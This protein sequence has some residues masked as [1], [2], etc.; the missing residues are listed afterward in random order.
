MRVLRLPVPDVEPPGGG[1][2]PQAAGRVSA[3]DLRRALLGAIL[4]EHESAHREAFA[5]CMH[6]LC[7]EARRLLEADTPRGKAKRNGQAAR[8]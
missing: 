1:P 3:T 2:T 8:P 7:R 4:Q 5:R 6:P